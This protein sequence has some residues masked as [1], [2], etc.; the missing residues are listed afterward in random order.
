MHAWIVIAAFLI[1]G[2]TPYMSVFER[3]DVAEWVDDGASDEAA[4]DPAQLEV[5]DAQAIARG[6]A[7]EA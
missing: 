7:E 3:N 4:D 6:D 2:L 1:V 5:A